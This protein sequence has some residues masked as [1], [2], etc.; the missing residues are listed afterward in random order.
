ME[1]RQEHT[2]QQSVKDA[3]DYPGVAT[4]RADD[5]KTTPCMVKEDVKELNNNPRNNDMDSQAK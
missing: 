2:E 4:D 3:L 5:D 1:K